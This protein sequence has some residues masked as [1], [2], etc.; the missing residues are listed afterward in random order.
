LPAA[1]VATE[2][3]PRALE[4][5]DLHHDA[6]ETRVVAVVDDAGLDDARAMIGAEPLPSALRRPKEIA[7][8]SCVTS[9]T[10]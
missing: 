9:G 8:S 3:R 2:A 5:G 10:A 7:L 6:A 1:S 4:P